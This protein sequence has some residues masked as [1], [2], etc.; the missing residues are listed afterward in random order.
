VAEA[1]ES[2]A[3]AASGVALHYEAE[4]G[5]GTLDPDR[6]GE[7][8]DRLRSALVSLRRREL[9]RGITLAGPHRDDCRLELQGLDA[10]THA[11]QGE[12]RT[13]ALALRLAGHRLIAG[14]VGSDPVLLLDDVFSELDPKRASALVAHLPGAQ[15]LLTTAGAVPAGIEAERL[16]EVRDGRVVT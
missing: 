10:R 3:G 4:W 14:V 1:Y 12:Q 13:L 11:S 9:D 16:L 8:E 2:L 15:T 6:A 5:E 7:V